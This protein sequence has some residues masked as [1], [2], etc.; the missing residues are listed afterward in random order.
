MTA[1]RIAYASYSKVKTRVD[2]SGIIL[3]YINIVES[4]VKIWQTV[5]WIGTEGIHEVLRAVEEV[6]T[7]SVKVAVAVCAV[8][9][10]APV[11][12]HIVVGRRAL[13]CEN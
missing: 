8:Q 12:V 1:P 3:G 4:P 7:R 13:E 6:V 10:I 11:D 5:A 2:S 9:K